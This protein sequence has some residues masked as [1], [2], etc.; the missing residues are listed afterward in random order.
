MDQEFAA[1]LQRTEKRLRLKEKFSPKKRKAITKKP[2]PETG[3]T[4]LAITILKLTRT[5]KCGATHT[6]ISGSYYLH[7]A[8]TA[9]SIRQLKEISAST[10]HNYPHLPRVMEERIE[11]TKL[12]KE[13][14][15]K[16]LRIHR[17]LRSRPPHHLTTEPP[18]SHI[19]MTPNGAT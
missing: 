19:A 9:T 18:R 7:R 1:L 10:L 17:H 14:R 11:K 6:T 4:D 16:A 15:E 13:A 8:H 12:S 5:C 3:W 2:L